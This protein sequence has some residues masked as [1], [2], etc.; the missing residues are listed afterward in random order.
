LL[1]V[2]SALETVVSDVNVFQRRTSTPNVLHQLAQKISRRGLVVLVTDLLNNFPT[3]ETLYPALQH[4]RHQ[5]HEVVIFHLLD[6]ETE[7]DFNFPNR[8]LILK[9]LESGDEMSVQPELIKSAYREQ[10]AH[11]RA[12]LRKRCR[13]FQIDIIDADIKTPFDKLLQSYL[14]KRRMMQK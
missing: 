10:M 14:I 13:E 6:Q 11:W 1:P 8:P 5:N 9:D 4:L 7:A 12:D 2:F 3:P